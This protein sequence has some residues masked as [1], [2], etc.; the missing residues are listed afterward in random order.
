[1]I[2]QDEQVLR[3]LHDSLAITPVVVEVTIETLVT[4]RAV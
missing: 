4:E 3:T 1:L 2:R